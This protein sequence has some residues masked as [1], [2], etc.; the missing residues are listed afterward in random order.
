[1]AKEKVGVMNA[2]LLSV[3]NKESGGLYLRGGDEGWKE[4]EKLSVFKHVNGGLFAVDVRFID[5]H[6]PH[7]LLDLNDPF[8][9]VKDIDE[10]SCIAPY[11]ADV[12]AQLNDTV[13]QICIHRDPATGFLFGMDLSYLEQIGDLI[14]HPYVDSPVV[15]RLPE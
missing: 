10:S 4:D 12:D 7:T 2:K 9:S 11:I 14:P 6:G 1:M 3:L 5:E 8:V 15:M 13:V